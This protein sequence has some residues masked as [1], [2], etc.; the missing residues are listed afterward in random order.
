MSSPNFKFNPLVE[1]NLP[2]MCDWLN[3]PHLQEWWREGEITLDAVCEKYLSRINNKD[4]AIPYLAI[5]NGKPEGFIQYYSVTEG[6]PNWWPDEPGPG[7]YGID[8]F[9]GDYNKLSRGF[10]TAMV[11]DFI[12]F[13]FNELNANEVLVDPRPDNFRAIRC[14]EKAGFKQVQPITNPDGP[15]IM[16][17]VK[18][19]EFL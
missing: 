16:M 19:Q 3:S 5:L 17:V 8:T 2:L 9:I 7:V 4:T 15:A 11:K 10:G 6:N 12:S 18:R 13:L 14:Y 1:S